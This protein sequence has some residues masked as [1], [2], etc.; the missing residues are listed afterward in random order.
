M[1]TSIPENNAWIMRSFLQRAK[2]SCSSTNAWESRLWSGYSCD[3][4]CETFCWAFW[5]EQ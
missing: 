3:F 4:L 1:F 5:N 2:N